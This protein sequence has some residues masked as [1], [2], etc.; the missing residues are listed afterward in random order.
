MTDDKTS[1]S[2]PGVSGNR[3]EPAAGRPA[4]DE[5][6]PLSGTPASPAPSAAPAGPPPTSPYAAE[7]ERRTWRDRLRSG[8]L[9]PRARAGVAAGAAALV[10][11]GVGGFA[12]GHATAG[13]GRGLDGHGF[14]GQGFG[15]RGFGGHDDHGLPPQ[16]Q[17]PGQQGQL[18]DQPEGSTGEL[19]DQPGTD[20]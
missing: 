14:G 1:A 16:G 18:P 20:S 10:V 15:G 13:D 9:G 11:G 7:P 12:L 4:T 17:L 19:P 3:W 6:A 8:R 5:T 2:T